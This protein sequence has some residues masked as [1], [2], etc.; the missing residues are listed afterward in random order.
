M[1]IQ[2]DVDT[3]TNRV[4]KSN[5]TVDGRLTVEN[6]DIVRE[7]V[8]YRQIV[9]DHDDV[10]IRT[11]EGPDDPSGAET[12]LDIKIGRRLIKHVAAQGLS[13]SPLLAPLFSGDM[14]LHIGLLHTDCAN[15]KSL[16]LT[17]RQQ[18]NVTIIDMTQLWDQS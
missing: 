4:G 15:G 1:T 3:L 13:V 2:E 18:R 9:L 5:Y 11:K 8:K 16:K 12:L 17:T 7:I 10:V 6:T 14:S